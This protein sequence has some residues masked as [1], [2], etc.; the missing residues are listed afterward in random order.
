VQGRSVERKV[1]VLSQ[2]WPLVPKIAN[3]VMVRRQVRNP[4]PHAGKIKMKQLAHL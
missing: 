1:Q 2:L 4:K 3:E